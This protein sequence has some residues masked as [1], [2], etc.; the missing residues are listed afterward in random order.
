MRRLVP[1]G[2]HGVLAQELDIDHAARVVLEVETT[3]IGLAAQVFAHP[4]AHG[5]DLTAQLVEVAFAAED[6]ATY[7]GETLAQGFVARHHACPNQ[8]LV[9]PGPGFAALVVGE[10]IELETSNPELPEG[11]RRM[12]TS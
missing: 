10:G 6:S 8:G 5:H 12:S 7:L 9:F 4:M 2:Q 3:G 1:H 11:R